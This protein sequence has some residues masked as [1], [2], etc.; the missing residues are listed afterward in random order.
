M[1]FTNNETEVESKTFS[2]NKYQNEVTLQ[3]DKFSDC[4]NHK[5]FDANLTEK[6]PEES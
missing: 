5:K 4:E 1:P 3:K 2:D 6:I